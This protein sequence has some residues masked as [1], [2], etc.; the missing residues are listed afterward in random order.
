MPILS[1]LIW[2][3]QYVAVT[4]ESQKRYSRHQNNPADIS[5]T[6]NPGLFPYKMRVD[7][8]P[9]NDDS[10]T[11]GMFNFIFKN[12]SYILSYANGNYVP[13]IAQ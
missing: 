8:Y 9:T 7:P 13:D 1:H 12:M 2:Q 5:F 6:A 11:K 10:L 3:A 4:S